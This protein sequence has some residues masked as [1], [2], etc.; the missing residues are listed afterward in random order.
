MGLPWLWWTGVGVSSYGAVQDDSAL[1][2][3][4]VG[5]SLG[6]VAKHGL[7][8]VGRSSFTAARF[9][10]GPARIAGSILWGAARGAA[11]GAARSPGA[12]AVAAASMRAGTLLGAAAT[13]GAVGIAILG[14]VGYL[15]GAA[16]P[17]ISGRQGF[18][19]GLE[20]GVTFLTDPV[21]WLE[22]L[23]EGSQAARDQSAGVFDYRVG[24]PIA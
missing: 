23:G 19:L 3:L 21:A 18:Y 20:G 11:V 1:F 10:A 15:Y 12:R 16:S 4:G 2:G 5:L 9:L 13:G 17:T 8:Q 24:A 6:G 14:P 22:R 7:V